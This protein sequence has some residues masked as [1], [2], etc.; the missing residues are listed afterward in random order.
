VTF[1]ID[2]I[3]DWMYTRHGKITGGLSIKYLLDQIP[4]H[5]RSDEQRAVLSM[6]EP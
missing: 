2:D 6:F 1:E 3:T 5:E 4:E